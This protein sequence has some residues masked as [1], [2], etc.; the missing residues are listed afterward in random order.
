MKLREL[1]DKQKKDDE[2]DHT[3]I[4]VSK[5]DKPFQ[6]IKIEAGEDNCRDVLHPCRFR[7][8]PPADPPGKR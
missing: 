7:L 3:G 5:P 6:V 4:A 1:Q 2:K 8:R